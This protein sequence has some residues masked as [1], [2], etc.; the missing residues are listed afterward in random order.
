METNGAPPVI[1][2]PAASATRRREQ[3][4]DR[5]RERDRKPKSILPLCN[6]VKQ[7]RATAAQDACVLLSASLSHS[8][9]C[10][11]QPNAHEGT[12]VLLFG[13]ANCVRRALDCE[14]VYDYMYVCVVYVCI[15]LLS[16]LG[17]F[18]TF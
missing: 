2:A 9:L 16:D 6:L 14:G 13:D 17:S 1:P 8:S 7:Q 10:K 15:L 3:N 12:D 18:A 11:L 5:D 4:R